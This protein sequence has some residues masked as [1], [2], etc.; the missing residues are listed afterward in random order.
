MRPAFANEAFFRLALLSWRIVRACVLP[1]VPHA[2]ATAPDTV[3]RL[4]QTRKV[5]PG[6]LVERFGFIQGR[7]FLRIGLWHDNSYEII[8]K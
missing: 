8:A 1:V 7:V 4:D 3:I 2:P 5:R 6:R